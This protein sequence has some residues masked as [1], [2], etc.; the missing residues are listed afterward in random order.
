LAQEHDVSANSIAHTIPVN[1]SGKRNYHTPVVSKG[2]YSELAN[3]EALPN[4]KDYLPN[5]EIHDLL[6]G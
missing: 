4:T 1:R 6:L 5:K 3:S 2:Q